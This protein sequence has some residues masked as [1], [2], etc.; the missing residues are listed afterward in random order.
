MKRSVVRW[1]ITALVL[2]VLTIGALLI[3]G[4]NLI[5]ATQQANA[6][7]EA[8]KPD[9]TDK[10]VDAFVSRLEADGFVVQEGRM[11]LYNY[12]SNCC[13]EG[14]PLPKCSFFNAASS[15]MVVYLPPSPGQ[16]TEEPAF[17]RDPQNPQWS[18]AWRLRPDEA[19]VFVGLAPPPMRYFG[20]QTYR[21]F[22]V[23]EQGQ[24][25]REWNNFG[26]QTNQLTIYTA[27]TPNGTRGDPFNSLTIRITT[28]DR[29][30]DARVREAASRAGYSPAIMNTEPIPQSVV[31]MGIDE[32]ADMFNFILRTALPDDPAELERYENP[33]PGEPPL[34]RVFRVTPATDPPVYPDT[35]PDPFPIPDFRIHGTG[36][37]EFGLL[38]AKEDLRQAILETYDGM[39]ADEFTSEQWLFYGLHHMNLSDDGIAPSIDALYLWLN[40][41][42]VPEDP[43][44]PPDPYSC[45][46]GSG[47]L[48]RG[49]GTLGPNDFVI[50]YGANH[51]QTG[52]AVYTNVGVYG[53][54]KQVTANLVND[55]KLLGSAADYLGP[56]YPDVNK[57]YAY[58]FARECGEEEHCFEVPYG[59]CKPEDPEDCIGEP[60]CAGMAADEEGT[61]IWRLY[62][63]PVAKT[64]ADP[65]EVILDHAIKFSPAP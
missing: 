41:V 64:G 2:A 23:N 3:P 9:R 36:Q 34:Y 43:S 61:I 32:D 21:G 48:R 10:K 19:V 54:T 5:P 53:M 13:P 47:T 62:L 40:E 52:K 39:H 14:S 60:G 16:E 17:T 63:D 31:R 1:S 58:K 65:A 18:L 35:S 33:D 26:D 37:T 46:S 4:H 22:T 15:Y 51:Q 12:V 55:P 8:P 44:N 50:V 57:L 42:C 20:F 59:C 30:I 56:D 49:F 38:P 45:I 7:S 11:A 28:A 6:Q 29:S 24:R 25:V 27:G